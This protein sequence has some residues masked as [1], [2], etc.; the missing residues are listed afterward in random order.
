MK[1]FDFVD[2]SPAI[3]KL[4]IV[5]GVERA[6]AERALDLVLDR[7][8]PPDVR[9]LN[10]QRFGPDDVGD[11]A[12]VREALGAMPFLAERRVVVVTEAQ[13]LRAQPRRDLWAVAQ[14]VPEGNVLVILDLLS[15]RAK[16][17][18]P[19]GPMAGRSATRIDTMADEAVRAR[20]VR[21]TL[22]RLGASAEPRAIDFL[23]RGEADLASVRNDLEKLALA[24]KKIA[25][26]DLE[27]ESLIS[28]DPK[29]YKYASAL[30]EGKVAQALAIAQDCFANEPRGAAMPLLSA[31]ATECGYLW[32]L[33]RE[34]GELPARARWR[35]RVLRPLAR[36][37]GERRARLAYERAVGGMEAIVTGAAGND[38]SD[39]QTLVERIT[40][41]LSGISRAASSGASRAP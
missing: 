18:E 27:R 5:E 2:K 15:P 13:A 20:F 12:R 30:V 25:L 32:E 31:L 41:E 38:P 36:R 8:L 1:F 23:S 22:E 35:E 9:E 17:P 14:D 26:V 11:G 34:G 29:A 3:G 33:A 16:R 37:V 4:V 10:L 40:V 24:G 28:E 19:Y 7:L 21:E 6:L 39:H